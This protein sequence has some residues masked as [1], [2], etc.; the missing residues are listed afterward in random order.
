VTFHPLHTFD[1]RLFSALICAASVLTAVKDARAAQ[2][3]KIASHKAVYDWTLHETKGGALSV[4]AAFGTLTYKVQKKCGV[5]ETET[6][7]DLTVAYDI[8]GVEKTSFRQ[9]TKESEDGCFFEFKTWSDK[10]GAPDVAGIGVCEADKKKIT[11]THPLPAE[12]VLP[13]SVLF[14]VAQTKALLRAAADGK[15]I[16]SSY[17]YDASKADSLHFVSAVAGKADADGNRLFNLAFY[18]DMDG[19]DRNDG[20]P[21]YE[22]DVRYDPNGAASGVIQRFDGYTLKS[23]LTSLEKLPDLPCAKKKAVKAL[24]KKDK[25]AITVPKAKKGHKKGA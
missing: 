2:T 3:V 13:R 16:F 9:E 5:Y 11:L 14:P 8:N 17:V 23:V 1:K 19:K 24:K 6:V 25:R 12:T 15:K 4:V 18:N 7:S 22:A 10:N 21:L 20:S